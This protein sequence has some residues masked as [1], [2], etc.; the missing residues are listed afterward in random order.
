MVHPGWNP[1]SLVIRSAGDPLSHVESIRT[2]IREIDPAVPIYDVRSLDDL[3]SQSFGSRRFNMYLLGCFAA[4]AATL[5]C[6]GL[7]GVLAYLVSQRRRD[8]GIRLALGATERDVITLVVGRGMVLALSGAAIGLGTAFVTG[9]VMKTLLFTVSPRDPW[10]FV[11]VPVVLSVVAL[12]ACYLPARRATQV[13][14]LVA[15]RA[16]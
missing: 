16:E 11:I 3:L 6:V 14:P 4:A 10:T 15:L 7:F 9:R 8:I 5:A 12:I 13:D 1:M 2:A